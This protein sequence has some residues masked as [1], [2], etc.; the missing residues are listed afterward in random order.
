M[1]IITTLV[2][3]TVANGI[4]A[5]EFQSLL[6]PQAAQQLREFRKQLAQQAQA[7]TIS[8]DFGMGAILAGIEEDPSS[9]TN[10]LSSLKRAHRLLEQT[11]KR[12]QTYLALQKKD[13]KPVPFH[14][15]LAL[16]S[17]VMQKLQRDDQYL[18]LSADRMLEK[19]S[20]LFDPKHSETNAEFVNI[21]RHLNPEKCARTVRAL[22]ILFILL[23]QEKEDTSQVENSL[24]HHYQ[25]LT[26]QRTGEPCALTDDTS[27]EHVEPTPVL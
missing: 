11:K 17:L 14:P 9:T 2:L 21:N 7:G 5:G 23:G 20:E 15:R 1:K 3:I 26:M 27:D 18:Q 24:K 25:M 8:L 6:L 13:S 4:Q 10:D 16:A 22:V 19:L 12:H